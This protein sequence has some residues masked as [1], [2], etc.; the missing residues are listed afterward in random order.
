ARWINPQVRGWINYYGKFNRSALYQTGY[1]IEYKLCLWA[2]KKYKRLKRS[3]EK[4]RN[5]LRRIR[6][7]HLRPTFAHWEFV[8]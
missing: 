8:S 5:W 1:Y 4:G 6:K 2:S 7:D 3:R